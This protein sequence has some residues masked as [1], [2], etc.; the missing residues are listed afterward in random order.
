[1]KLKMNGKKKNIEFNIDMDMS[2]DEFLTYVKLI[3]E[4]IKLMTDNELQTKQEDKKFSDYTIE[5]PTAVAVND[6]ELRQIENAINYLRYIAYGTTEE[7]LACDKQI[8][9][10]CVENIVKLM[11]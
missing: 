10:T 5:K 9:Y 7:M 3:P 1:M 2:P 4:F 8:A 11:K 6:D